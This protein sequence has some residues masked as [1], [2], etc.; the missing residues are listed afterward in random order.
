MTR[1]RPLRRARRRALRGARP[2]LHGDRRRAAAA[3]ACASSWRPSCARA[4]TGS[5]LAGAEAPSALSAAGRDRD[6]TPRSSPCCWPASP[7]VL[8]GRAWAAALRRGELRDRAGFRAS[9]HYTQGLHYLAAG[10]LELAVSE[11]A[12]VAREDPDAVEVLQVLGNLLREAGQVE[13]AIQVHQALLARARPHARRARA[14]AGLAGHRLPQGRLPRPRH[15]APSSEVLAVDPKNIHALIGLQKLQEEQRQWREAYELQTRL[16][17]AAQDRRQPRARLPAGGDGPARRWRAGD[18]EAAEKAFRT[19][20]SLDRRVFPAHLGL[21]DLLRRRATR[22]QAAAIL[23]DAIQAAPERAYLAFDRLARAYAAAGEPSRFAALCERIIRAGPARLARAAG[24]GPPP[25]RGGPGTR[26]RTGCCCAPWRRTRRCWPSH[27]EIV[28]R[29][30]DALGLRPRRASSATWRTAEGAVFYRDPHIC[31]AC[32][33]RAD[34]MLW[35]CPHCHEWNT[36]VEER[37]G[38]AR[39]RP[40]ADATTAPFAAET[41]ETNAAGRGRR[42][43]RPVLRDSAA[44]RLGGGS[45]PAAGGS[46]DQRRRP[47]GPTGSR[48]GGAARPRGRRDA[49]ARARA[50]LRRRAPERRRPSARRARA[51]CRHRRSCAGRP[52]RGRRRQRAGH[53][54]ASAIARGSRC[55]RRATVA[56]AGRR[57]VRVVAAPGQRPTARRRGQRLRPRSRG[58]VGRAARYQGPSARRDA[59]ARASRS[60]SRPPAASTI[61]RAARPGPGR[62]AR[63]PARA[64]ARPAARRRG[65]GGA[66]GARRGQRAQQPAA[67]RPLPVGLVERCRRCRSRSARSGASPPPASGPRCARARPPPSS[68]SRAARRSSCCSGR[69][70]TTTRRSKRRCMPAST[71]SAASVTST[72]PVPRQR[73]A[74][75]ASSSRTRGW[76]SALSRRARPRVRE[77]ARAQRL[78]IDGPVRGPGCR[79][80]TRATT[81]S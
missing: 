37:V 62:A 1:G 71:S 17:P 70:S 52:A 30:C 7:G 61:G 53:S 55:V 10:Q 49:R 44:P 4:G 19:A 42:Q 5:A 43:V 35:R 67:S 33:Y 63:A 81:S 64:R 78:A 46:A 54:V 59:G 36:F 27:L 15:A 39:P 16:S 56:A 66:G 31:T 60:I 26:R 29:R 47:G 25:A 34:D 14:R 32:R 73:A 72:A 24:P 50:R 40:G 28:A 51:S 18:R 3:A 74:R 77:H 11:L 41:R 48:G 76:T 58:A 57:V 75:R 12:K 80:R 65:T 6:A 23:E 8:A 20:L 22:A 21:A 2:G 13:R 9:P 79:G 68:P 69:Q 38:P 45:V